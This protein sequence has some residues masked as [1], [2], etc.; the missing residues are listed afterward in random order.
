MWV[1][2]ISII[3]EK[4]LIEVFQNIDVKALRSA[5]E[6]N[7]NIVG[8]IVQNSLANKIASFFSLKKMSILGLNL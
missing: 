2:Q 8:L 6:S 4:S 1:A 5:N 7:N 3:Q